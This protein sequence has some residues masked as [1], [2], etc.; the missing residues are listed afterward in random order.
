[1]MDDHKANGRAQPG[2]AQS[3]LSGSFFSSES[4]NEKV[5]YTYIIN[6]C[7]TNTIFMRTRC[8]RSYLENPKHKLAAQ[9]PKHNLAAHKLAEEQNP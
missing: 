3:F 6:I 8:I 9:N 4:T 7:Y 5:I 1:M 2:G